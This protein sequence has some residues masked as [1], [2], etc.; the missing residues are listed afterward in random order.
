[1]VDLVQRYILKEVFE[2][3]TKEICLQQIKNL[4]EK[5]GLKRVNHLGM[6]SSTH[7]KT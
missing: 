7:R 1:M 2:A 3:K 6:K 4:V 5:K